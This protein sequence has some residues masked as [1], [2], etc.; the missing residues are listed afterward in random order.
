[1]KT[2][3]HCGMCV[4][5][6]VYNLLG[7]IL[8]AYFFSDGNIN[9]GI[10]AEKVHVCVSHEILG[11]KCFRK[12]SQ[13]TP[14]FAVAS[15]DGRG[16]CSYTFHF[17]NVFFFPYLSIRSASCPSGEPK[18]LYFRDSLNC[19]VRWHFS[20]LWKSVDITWSSQRESLSSRPSERSTSCQRKKAR[21]DVSP[22]GLMHV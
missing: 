9:D 19:L 7:K 3:P 4:C 2:A 15:L 14:M 21:Y 20:W 10:L 17:A 11:L 13:E 12:A 16:R 22:D 6:C 18:C 1:M 5:V 8:F